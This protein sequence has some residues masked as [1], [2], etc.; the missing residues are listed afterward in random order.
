MTQTPYGP[1]TQAVQAFIDR[2]CRL[3]PTDV[4][5]LIEAEQSDT[6][7]VGTTE[8]DVLRY[9][10]GDVRDPTQERLSLPIA[11]EALI[12]NGR[13]DD[14]R[15]ALADAWSCVPPGIA[16]SVS[17]IAP[18]IVTASS[19]WMSLEEIIRRALAGETAKD[20]IDRRTFWQLTRPWRWSGLWGKHAGI[21]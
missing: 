6:P 13:L 4:K 18:E 12:G 7:L 8:E 16:G 3:T 1:N 21:H 9:L 17:T 11:F 20:L 19:V 10:A 5:V 14:Y 2:I 15:R